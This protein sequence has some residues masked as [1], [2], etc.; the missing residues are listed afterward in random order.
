M[1]KSGWVAKFGPAIARGLRRRQPQPGDIW[2]L[3]EVARDD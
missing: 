1:G 2:H 3:D